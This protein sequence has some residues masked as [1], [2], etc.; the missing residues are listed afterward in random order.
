[1]EL[2]LNLFW[3][4]LAVPALWYWRHEP[5][6]ARKAS[7]FERFR[8]FVLIGCTLMLLFPVI[9]A[10]D[11]MRAMGQVMEERA[12]SERILKQYA[13]GEKSHSHLSGD[14]T[15]PATL[16][17]SLAVAPTHQICGQVV[18]H[19]ILL[20]EQTLLGGMSCRAPPALS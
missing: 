3:L 17:Y 7:G 11:D 9:S 18:A 12:P 4:M 19:P 10:T 15:Y 20:P 8:P 14:G 5:A 1:M 16:V 13:G 6:F 2:L